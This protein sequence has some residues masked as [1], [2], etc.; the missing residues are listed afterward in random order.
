M[1]LLKGGNLMKIKFSSSRFSSNLIVLFLMVSVIFILSSMFRNPAYAE[2][3]RRSYTNDA[4]PIISSPPAHTE[5]QKK[6]FTDDFRIDE[7]TFLASG[8]NPYFIP[9]VPGAQLTLAGE[10][11]KEAVVVVITVLED[12]KNI[13]LDS[14]TIIARVIEESET[15]DGELVEVSRNW[16][17]IC[18][19]TNSVFYFGEDVDIYEGGIIVSHDGSWE[20]GVDGATPGIMMPGTVLLGS[21]YYQ[22]IAEG[23]A[24]DRAEHIAMDVTVDSLAGTFENCLQTLETT[25]LEP[26]AK[27][28]KIYAPGIGLVVDGSLTLVEYVEP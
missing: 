26:Y 8:Q 3:Q 16:F 9:L 14:G 19:E 23:V 27:D 15:K 11:G 6:Q 10:E 28:T 20:A 22:E 1:L 24:L 2:N 7:C 13:T 25:P 12:T 4:R 18:E 5:N 21:R 17:A